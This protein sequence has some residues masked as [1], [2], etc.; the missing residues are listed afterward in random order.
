MKGQPVTTAADT[1]KDRGS[2]WV[3]CLWVVG[4]RERVKVQVRG[5]EIGHRLGYV[6]FV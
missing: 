5:R 2:G 4:L 1:L 6:Y 3:G